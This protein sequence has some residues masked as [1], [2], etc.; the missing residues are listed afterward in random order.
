MNQF[1]KSFITEIQQLTQ[2]GFF[3]CSNNNFGEVFNRDLLTVSTV[4][5]QA[6]SLI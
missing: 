3:M 2:N 1:S 6:R 5:L 4:D